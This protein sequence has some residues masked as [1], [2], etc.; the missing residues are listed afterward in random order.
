MEH[1]DIYRIAALIVKSI[2]SDISEEELKEL[3]TWR[4]SS[5]ENEC[6]YQRYQ[7]AEYFR[8]RSIRRE[9]G[10]SERIRK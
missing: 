6:L 10:S 5:K 3:D 1:N 9:D 8:E 4:D 2:K 7:N